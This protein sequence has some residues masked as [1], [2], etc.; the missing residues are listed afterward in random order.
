MIETLKA[1]INPKS[2]LSKFHKETYS[3]EE[4]IVHAIFLIMIIDN[5]STGIFSY[6]KIAVLIFLFHYF[7]L[8]MKKKIVLHASKESKK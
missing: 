4:G 1:L 7:I 5:K 8:Q 2:A 6:I 3:W